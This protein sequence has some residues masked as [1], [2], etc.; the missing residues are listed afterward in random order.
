MRFAC[1]YETRSGV[2]GLIIFSSNNRHNA[3][4]YVEELIDYYGHSNIYNLKEL[5]AGTVEELFRLYPKV[6]NVTVRGNVNSKGQTKQ[7][8]IK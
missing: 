7:E 4:I 1:E 6:N 3:E 5:T 2:T 8:G